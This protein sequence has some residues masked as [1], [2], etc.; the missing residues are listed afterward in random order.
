MRPGASQTASVFMVD[1]TLTLKWKVGV[2]LSALL[3][4]C[5]S[6]LRIEPL[7]LQIRKLRRKT[8]HFHLLAK[9]LILLQCRMLRLCAS[10][11]RRKLWIEA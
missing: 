6:R 5:A 3:T 4:S 11:A 7:A 9:R 1:T 8:L 2:N 10:V